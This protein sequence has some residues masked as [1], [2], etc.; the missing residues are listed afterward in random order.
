MT[1]RDLHSERGER[2]ADE[3]FG[4]RDA[5]TAR[6]MGLGSDEVYLLLGGS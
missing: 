1:K 6:K 2:Q 4:L 3:S 5:P